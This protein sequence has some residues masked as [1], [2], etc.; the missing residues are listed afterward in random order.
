MKIIKHHL[1]DSSKTIK[2]IRNIESKTNS[3][4]IVLFG[5]G[6]SAGLQN[7]IPNNPPLGSQLYSQLQITF[8]HSWGQIP[9][10]IDDRFREHFEEGMGEIWEHYS[11]S[12]PRLMREMAVYF[13][14][15]QPFVGA[16]NLYQQFILRNIQKTNRHLIFSSLNYDLL[17]ELSISSVDNSIEYFVEQSSNNSIPVWK[18]HGSANFIPHGIQATGGIQFTRGINFETSLRYCSPNEAKQFCQSNTALYP[19][20]CLFMNSKPTQIAHNFITE[21]QKKWAQIILNA[22]K[23]LII[24]VNPY[25]EDNHIWKSL[26]QTDANI[27]FIGG[28]EGFDKW[29]TSGRDEDNSVLIGNRWESVFEQSVDFLT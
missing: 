20:M 9:S 16:E 10:N 11:T 2:K 15:F 27:G 13:L 26:T 19:A 25:L 8:P 22:N 23:V 17:L 12:V 21:Q 14:Q 3:S 18:L 29:I 1:S 6:A 24:G 5:A 4:N 28:K 7:I